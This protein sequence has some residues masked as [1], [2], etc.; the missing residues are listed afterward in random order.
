MDMEY[1]YTEY[2]ENIHENVRN[3]NGI[4]IE[5]SSNEYG[6]CMQFAWAMSGDVW[7]WYGMNMRY[8]WN[9][10]RVCVGYMSHMYAICM[11]DV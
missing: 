6:R 10:H 11:A 9:M 7:N 2:V 1:L 3:I 5:Y 8:V 4:S